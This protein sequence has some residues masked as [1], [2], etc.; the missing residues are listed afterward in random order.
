MFRSRRAPRLA[1][2]LASATLLL[3]TA[4]GG[5]DSD[6]DTS[7]AGAEASTSSGGSAFP[8]SIDHKYGSTT[9][10]AEPER[11]VTV[12]LTDQDAVLALGKVPVGTTE[13]LGGYKGAIGPWAEDKLGSAKAPTVLKD[14][15]TGPQ[16]E[17]IAA[18]KPDLILAVYGG[19]TKDQ[20]ESL[21]KFAP[22]VAQPKAY[23]DYGVPWQEQTETIGRALGKE[24]EA[25]EAVADTEAKIKAAAD[26]YPAFKGA[27]AVMATPYEGMFV[28]GSEDARSRLLTG[29][30]FSLP[31]DL[32]KA[33][34]DRFGA[35]ISKE[36]TDLLDQDVIVWIVGDPAK[37]AAKL[38][39][40]ASYKDLGVVKEGREV[41][42]N[43]SSDYGNATSFVSVLSLP[44]VVER[45]AP[46][47]AAAVD[48]KTDT[49]VEQPAS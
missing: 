7:G 30:G 36:R 17:K 13:W 20:Y 28:F 10:E 37:D 8:V 1:V 31:A 18:L 47:L 14:T 6:S 49:E 34:G 25:T 9:I 22:V 19:L 32:D 26:K 4:C 11:I 24:K 35:N 21:S 15:G 41:F 3:A 45:L 27:T 39:K 5:G 33:I 48:G 2:V 43:E 29:L 40:D 23:N 42:V 46:Q 38:H 44:Y 12:G 16:V